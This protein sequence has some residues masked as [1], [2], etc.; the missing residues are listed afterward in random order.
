MR[1]R[2]ILVVIVLLIAGVIAW[3][4]L[5]SASTTDPPGSADLPPV[6]GPEAEPQSPAEEMMALAPSHL[7]ADFDI[8]FPD[9][10]GVLAIAGNPGE[11]FY[12][13]TENDRATVLNRL[14]DGTDVALWSTDARGRILE[15]VGSVGAELLLRFTDE[16]YTS[17]ADGWHPGSFL[18][19]DMFSP[20]MGPY[21]SHLK[22]EDVDAIR[23]MLER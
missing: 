6:Q 18:A 10:A 19:L 15:I 1:R 22:A 3:G 16:P 7:A 21:P 5:R 12:T 9:N 17:R 23:E 4:M 20:G 13:V 2:E 11:T 14:A 8:E